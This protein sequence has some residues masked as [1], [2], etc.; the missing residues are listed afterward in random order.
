MWRSLE[1]LGKVKAKAVSGVQLK[2]MSTVMC[3]GDGSQ[4]AVGSPVGLGLH[5]YEPT[6]VATLPSDIVSVH[7][8]HYH[9]LAL[10]SHGHLW[11]WGRNNEAQLGRGP[12]SRESWHEPERVKGLESVKVCAAFASG[13]VSAAVGDDGSVW[14]W[15][16]SKRGQL[17]L[18]ENITNALVP[19]KVEALS[20]ENVS[21]ISFGWGH[22][23]A[24]TSDGKLFGW[25]YSADGRIGKMGNRFETSPLESTFRNNS[26]LSSSDLKDAENRVLQGMEQEN[27]I[28]I[29]WEPRLVEELR[30]VHVVD[31]ACGLDHS[32]VLC[33]DGMLL[34]C[35]SNV[36]GQLGR[37]EADLGIFPVD[38]SFTPIF[39]AAG[40][41][42]SL[43]ICQLGESDGS[44]GTTNIASWGWNL[45]SQLGRLGDG[46]VPSFIDALNGENPVSV[47]AG[48]AHSLALTSKGE[49]WL[50]GSGKSGRL[51]L[52]T[53]ADQV[54]PFCLDSLEG[55]QILQAVAGF[56]HNLILVAG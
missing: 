49:L 33:R 37:A 21:K 41:G 24:R 25:G 55:F 29:V 9:S 53:S 35:G 22:A 18:G 30:G 40:L 28:P 10:T 13:V 7:A 48:R 20:G 19:T 23:L 8:G 50:W 46:K 12:S 1:L 27:D 38:M 39:I 52:A 17:G 45:S 11:A 47:S 4:G 31:I 34:S 56:D 15:G 26:Q 36:Y 43:A 42:H 54:E 3:L 2:W 5:A 16:K 14:V 32:L 44:V 51:G 6:P